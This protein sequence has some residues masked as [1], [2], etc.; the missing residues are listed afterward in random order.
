MGT[1]IAPIISRTLLSILLE[2]GKE[3]SIDEMAVEAH[4]RYGFNPDSIKK[5]FPSSIALYIPNNITRLQNGKYRK[6]TEFA[7]IFEFLKFMKS[8]TNEYIDRFAGLRNFYNNV[9]ER[10]YMS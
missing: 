10:R 9:E 3:L 7:D 8:Q 2:E 6:A 4:K 5:E 1:V